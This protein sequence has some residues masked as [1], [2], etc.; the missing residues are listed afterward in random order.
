M[1]L[2]NRLDGAERS[3]H[4][5]LRILRRLLARERIR[6]RHCEDTSAGAGLSVQT[7]T[8]KQRTHLAVAPQVDVRA[9]RREGRDP[10]GDVVHLGGLPR[11]VARI[12][13][14]TRVGV[15]TSARLV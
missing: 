1:D 13:R 6:R 4:L 12:P 14:R 10:V 15:G 7:Q 3:L 2:L 5:V 9:K 11:A 8:R